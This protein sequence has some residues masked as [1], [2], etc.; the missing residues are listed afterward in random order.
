MQAGLGTAV[1]VAAMG[2][3]RAQDPLAS[4]GI[5]R[6]GRPAIGNVLEIVGGWPILRG[7]RLPPV[8]MRRLD[9]SGTDRS[10][11][12]VVASKALLAAPTLLA[13]SAVVSPVLGVP[14]AL[15][16]WRVPDLALARLARRTLAAADREIPVLLDL[17]A[18]ATSAG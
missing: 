14:A 16:A 10:A 4:S 17:L 18:V 12:Q 15:I 13:V 2:L 6:G 8:T 3:G 9:R 1:A 7:V 11:R 5:V